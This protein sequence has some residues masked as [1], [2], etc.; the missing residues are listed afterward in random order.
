MILVSRIGNRVQVKK[1]LLKPH[2]S[3]PPSGK[4]SVRHGGGQPFHLRAILITMRMIWKTLVGKYT[5]TT[6]STISPT[7]KTLSDFLKNLYEMHLYRK[8]QPLL[9]L[10]R[11]NLGADVGRGLT[12]R[13]LVSQAAGLIWLDQ[14][15]PAFER[16]R[17]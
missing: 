8:G 15:C 16:P 6:S 14:P 5:G 13:R 17:C 11:S 3:T 7:E 4:H 9:G 10:A 1:S 2:S 12:Q